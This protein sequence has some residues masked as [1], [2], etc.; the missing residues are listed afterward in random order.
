MPYFTISNMVLKWAFTKPVTRNYPFTPRL[1]IPGSRGQLVFV[2]GNCTFCT[3]CGK[4]CPTKAIV[5]NRASKKWTLDRLRCISCGSCVEICPK[6]CLTL[7]T[8]HG[9]PTVT[10]DKEIHSGSATS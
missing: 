9:A 3:V 10:K 8:S 7:S 2:Q 6:D 1:D 5:V 4:K